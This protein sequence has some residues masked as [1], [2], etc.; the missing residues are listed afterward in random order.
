[1]LSS[2]P[3]GVPATINPQEVDADIFLNY[4]GSSRSG[5]DR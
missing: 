5:I 3:G 2:S 1:L 4:I